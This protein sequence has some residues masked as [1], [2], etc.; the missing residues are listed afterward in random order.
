MFMRH[1][2]EWG[3]CAP[4]SQTMLTLHNQV[5]CSAS[6]LEFAGMCCAA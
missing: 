2:P 1:H 4:K 6:N 3:N 5:E